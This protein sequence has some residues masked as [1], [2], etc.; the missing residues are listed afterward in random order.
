M[1]RTITFERQFLLYERN[2]RRPVGLRSRHI[3]MQTLGISGSNGIETSSGLADNSVIIR[4]SNLNEHNYSREIS[5]SFINA[6][7]V[8]NRTGILMLPITAHEAQPTEIISNGNVD[9]IQ[10][11]DLSNTEIGN[12]FQTLHNLCSVIPSLIPTSQIN[13]VRVSVFNE[14]LS[15]LFNQYNNLVDVFDRISEHNSLI[16]NGQFI[17]RNLQR[18][19][20]NSLPFN[21]NQTPHLTPSNYNL[22]VNQLR[23]EYITSGL[24][25]EQVNLVEQIN[26]NMWFSNI[27]IRPP[28]GRN[29]IERGAVLEVVTEAGTSFG[30]FSQENLLLQLIISGE[31]HFSQNLSDLLALQNRDLFIIDGDNEFGNIET[32]HHVYNRTLF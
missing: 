8:A 29:S 25:E 32:H 10:L 6:F 31:N 17:G 20:M 23:N 26:G 11:N 22:F 12:E 3:F 30:R 14:D 21:L 2:T 24:T 4:T 5:N 27:R 9:G 7:N 15:E 16:I 18:N 1:S 28:M 19:F 13:F